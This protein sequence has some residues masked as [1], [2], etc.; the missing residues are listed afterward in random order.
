MT[1]Q[2]A[3]LQTYNNELVKSLEELK[4]RRAALQ[5]QIEAESLE[6]RKLESEKA[7][8][9]ERL[10]LVNSSLEEKMLTGREYDRVIQEAE[11]A[12]TKIL[13][14]SQVLLN[15]VQTKSQDLRCNPRE[16]RRDSGGGGIREEAGLTNAHSRGEDANADQGDRGGNNLQMEIVNQISGEEREEHPE[17][18]GQGEA[19][20]Q[21]VYGS[22]EKG[23]LVSEAQ[24]G[25]QDGRLEDGSDM[26]REEERP[27]SRATSTPL[28]ATQAPV[29]YQDE[30]DLVVSHSGGDK[31]GQA[32]P[33]KRLGMTAEQ[34]G[35]GNVEDVAEN[36]ESPVISERL[37]MLC[38]EAVVFGNMNNGN[39]S[40]G[41]VDI[42]EEVNNEVDMELDHS[43][44]EKTRD[45][46]I[47][48]GRGQ[49]QGG[50]SRS[51]S[52]SPRKLMGAHCIYSKKR[53]S[54]LSL[55]LHMKV[56]KKTAL[57]IHSQESM[58]RSRII[59]STDSVQKKMKL[60]KGTPV[61]RDIGLKR[62]SGSRRLL[63]KGDGEIEKTLKPLRE[64]QTCKKT[65]TKS[66]GNTC[67]ACG[68]VFHKRCSSKKT[69]GEQWLCKMCCSRQKRPS[70]P[71]SRNKKGATGDQEGDKVKM[72]KSIAASELLMHLGRG[73][74]E[75]NNKEVAKKRTFL[76]ENLAGGN[77]MKTLGG[78]QGMG[79]RRPARS[80][81]KKSVGWYSQFEEE[82]AS[83]EEPEQTRQQQFKCKDCKLGFSS[84]YKLRRHRKIHCR[85]DI[86]T[87]V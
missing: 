66:R 46:Q 71:T 55:G 80:S 64:C 74:E 70:K 9:E 16:E 75:N 13:E 29:V 25:A 22:T 69:E 35:T 85:D 27:N 37:A 83:Q 67:T 58:Q 86:N 39:I 56:V 73:D 26:G 48:L 78:I 60:E 87:I 81:A 82:H 8:L 6:K 65:V 49:L 2:G 28:A 45:S 41:N 20:P 31:E 52:L 5:Q 53:K 79:N 54:M 12:F 59:E 3:A 61:I 42:N 33:K 21:V 36:L 68:E 47:S 23:L 24:F 34:S 44:M 63:K 30:S 19:N 50:N 4:A 76:T 1:Q 51:K 7:R 14:S 40:E 17:T 11:Q 57:G 72:N 62:G 84:S 10:D 32:K 43:L 77:G 18:S 15:V 38:S